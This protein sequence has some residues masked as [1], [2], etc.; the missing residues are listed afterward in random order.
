MTTRR[1]IAGGAV[2]LETGTKKVFAS[3]LAWPGWARAGR[4]EDAALAALAAYAPRFAPIAEAARDPLGARIASGLAVVERLHGNATT[5]F[6]APGA[7]AAWDRADATP[8]QRARLAA[9][10][11]AAWAELDRIAA[12]APRELRKGPR[13][14]GRDRD[15]VVAHV[16]GAEAGYA[17]RLGLRKVAEPDAADAAAV[18]E[19]RQR[20]LGALREGTGVEQEPTWPARYAAR[21]FAWH[22]LDHAWEIEDRSAPA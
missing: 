7:I 19:L 4:D 1:G 11:E 14:G 10:L 9:F 18:A 13:G 12:A 22:V 8:A 6:G 2:A 16:V 3:A 15:A 5:D 20:V 17:R 21:R